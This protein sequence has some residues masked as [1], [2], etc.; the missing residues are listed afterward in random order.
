MLCVKFMS[1]EEV[2]GIMAMYM[3]EKGRR[4]RQGPGEGNGHDE[5]MAVRFERMVGGLDLSEGIGE[6]EMCVVSMAAIGACSLC[7]LLVA[8]RTSW[9][10]RD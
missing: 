10:S 9:W 6:R 1:L 4:R 2:T 5:A 3:S 7:L 8:S